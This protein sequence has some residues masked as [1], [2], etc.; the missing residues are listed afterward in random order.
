MS[1][2]DLSGFAETNITW[3]DGLLAI[4]CVAVGWI[5]SIFAHRGVLALLHKT[6]NVGEGAAVLLA[7]IS[8]YGLILLG[9]GVGLSFL[10]A[11]MQPLLA[12]TLLLIAMAVLVLKGAADNFAAGVLLQTR[13]PVNL[14]DEIEVDGI[15]G[16]VKE[17]N[18]RSVVLHTQDGRTIRV[19]NAQL[20]SEP[21][22][23]HSARGARRSEVQVRVTRENVDVSE[24]VALLAHAVSKAQGVRT[25]QPVGVLALSISPERIIMRVQY[26]HHPLKANPVT[27]AVIIVISEALDARRIAG[28]I[29]SDTGE[30]PLV[31]PDP[32]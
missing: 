4:A 21:I 32:L 24:L 10:G 17:L 6:P 15:A 29:T 3:V 1:G 18:G 5:L 7:R 28:V 8:K 23:N 12:I 22:I 27:S 11:S 31:P 19:P 25:K 13:H 20:I 9:A 30:P 2:I 16:T 14:G 26:W